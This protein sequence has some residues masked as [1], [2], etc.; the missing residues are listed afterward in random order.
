MRQ[1][2]WWP[3]VKRMS[4]FWEWKE[5]NSN[6]GGR[7]TISWYQDLSLYPPSSTSMF[8]PTWVDKSYLFKKV[9]VDF[10]VFW[11]L[12]SPDSTACW[13]KRESMGLV[14]EQKYHVCTEVFA[15]QW[16]TFLLAFHLRQ[17]LY[18]PTNHNYTHALPKWVHL[19]VSV[20]QES[21]WS[22]AWKFSG[23]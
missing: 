9:W 12:C 16:V 8:P 2:L 13:V 23:L 4:L 3:T 11:I 15:I 22:A 18:I 20:T 6:G 14:N 5:E 10:F 19:R 1:K 17:W 7:K 21:F